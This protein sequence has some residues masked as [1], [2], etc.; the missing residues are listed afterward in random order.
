MADRRGSRIV[1]TLL[2][3]LATGVFV[4][5]N[6]PALAVH[7]ADGDEPGSTD[8]PRP[9]QATEPA[10]RPTPTPP[11]EPQG[12][13]PGQQPQQDL[14]N[15]DPTTPPAS[16]NTAPA[17]G[18][19]IQNVQSDDEGTDADAT[20]SQNSKD[21]DGADTED[22]QK[23][24]DDEELDEKKWRIPTRGSGG[25]SPPDYIAPSDPKTV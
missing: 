2:A 19:R 22:G 11:V 12:P 24:S 13:P 6:Q 25:D 4:G 17:D 5:C 23:E 10:D 3:L 15:T 16:D 18:D 9:A 1:L 7:G 8:Q 20:D 21:D 14:P